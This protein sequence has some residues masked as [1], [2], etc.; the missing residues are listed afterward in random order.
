MLGVVP[1]T[2]EWHTGPDRLSFGRDQCV[3]AALLERTVDLPIRVTSIGCDGPDSHPS[4]GFD[5]VHLRFD[6]L[7]F[8]RLSGCDRDIENNADFV[9][10][11]RV[12]LVSGLQPSVA[13]VRGHRRVRIGGADL[14]VLPGLPFFFSSSVSSS[15][16]FS[17]STSSTCRS[18]RL[19][20]LT[21]ARIRDASMCTTSAVAIFAFKQAS[22]VRLK[23][24]Q[25][26]SSPQR[27]RMR[28]RLE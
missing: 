25:N 17:L 1:G 5:L 27:W 13:S 26:R 14:L 9:I 4:G 28:V 23:I 10:D 6:H 3:N 16:W 12:L 18:T 19:S 20:Q 11:G 21:L 22:T 7:S 24:L 2:A 15:L 8:I